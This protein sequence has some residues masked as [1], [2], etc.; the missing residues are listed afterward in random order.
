MVQLE[1]ACL[2]WTKCCVRSPAPHKTGVL[3]HVQDLSG[4]GRRIIN[5]RSVSLDPFSKTSYVKNNMLVISTFLYQ[6]ALLYLLKF[7][8]SF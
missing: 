7:F 8:S 6:M 3:L 5:S 4:R 2:A 1:S